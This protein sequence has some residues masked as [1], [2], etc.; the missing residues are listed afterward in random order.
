MTSSRAELKRLFRASLSALVL[1]HLT[2]T[3]VAAQSV[4]DPTVD[5][6]QPPG[7]SDESVTQTPLAAPKR[8]L[9]N[10]PEASEGS[11][12]NA[13]DKLRKRSGQSNIQQK[14]GIQTE[15]VGALDAQSIG[16]LSVREGG[17]GEAM[18]TGTS[19]T[20][21]VELIQRL[22]DTIAMRALRRTQRRVLLSQAFAPQG[23]AESTKNLLEARIEKLMAMGDVPGR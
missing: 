19:R 1:T 13:L 10:A 18:W 16:V 21:A 15:A 14:T 17:F 9:P 20:Q 8:L 3:G 5:L 4:D 6:T 11:G 7:F 23:G 2:I 12:T 22:P